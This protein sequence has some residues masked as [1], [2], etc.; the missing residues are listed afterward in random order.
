MN[1]AGAM[2]VQPVHHGFDHSYVTD[3]MQRH[4]GKFKASLVIDPCLLRAEK[5][6]M[7]DPLHMSPVLG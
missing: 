2:I 3:V 5:C 7:H 4:P 6:A 1:V